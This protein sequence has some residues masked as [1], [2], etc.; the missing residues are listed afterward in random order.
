LEDGQVRLILHNT[1][2]RYYVKWHGS[3]MFKRR[4]MLHN[5]TIMLNF[6]RSYYVK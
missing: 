3:C 4:A 5:V 6:N 1:Q 2:I